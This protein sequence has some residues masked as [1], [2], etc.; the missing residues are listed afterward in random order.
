[1]LTRRE[2]LIRSYCHEPMDRPAVYSRTGFPK[3]DPSYDR[4]KA[5]L[6]EKT[7][8]KIGWSGIQWE[9]D[10]PIDRRVEPVSEDFNRRVETLYTP[11]G[12][13]TQT[14]LISRK[15]QPGLV[16]TSFVK[17]AADIER[18]LSLPERRPLL[19]RNDFQKLQAEMGDAGIVEVSLGHNPGGTTVEWCGQS[20]F[21]ELSV[22][23]RELLY[24][25]CE[26]RLR[27]ILAVLDLYYSAGIG[28]FY[29]MA[30]EEY[31]VPPMHGPQDFRDF[32][33]RYDRPIVDRIH[34]G[35]GRIHIH[36]HGSLKKVFPY[37]V[38]M[39]VDVLHPVEAPPLGDLSAAEAKSM[40]GGRLTI[41]GNIQI[42]RLYE[43]DPVSI[44][45]ETARL[46]EDAFDDHQG[47]IVSPTASPYIR[48]AGEQCFPQYEAMVETVLEF[49]S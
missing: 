16:E 37:F 34:D 30:G 47:L 32:N 17:E 21:A 48:G 23:H 1:M 15:G 9:P 46:I 31:V 42:H 36:C 8:L 11:K 33:M 6:R 5:Y 3:D 43:A 45:E 41:E 38:E 28:P 40:A 26:R 22:T 25:L 29:A 24:C 13:L 49:A 14:L 12:D 39:G 18:L 10:W 35:G 44:R 19:E 20:L 7:E 2:R 4:L 27:E